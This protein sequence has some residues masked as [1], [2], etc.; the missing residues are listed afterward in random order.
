MCLY[1]DDR[2]QYATI[3]SILYGPYLLAGHST[4]DWDVKTGSAQSLS[5]WITPVPT[6]YNQF[7]VTF[8]QKSGHSTFV[9]ANSNHTLTMEKYPAVGTDAALRATFRLILSDKPSSRS[10]SFK[11][12]IGKSVMLEPIN[13]PGMLVSRDER[14]NKLV[15]TSSSSNT[16]SSIFKLVAGVDGNTETVSLESIGQKGCFIS[17]GTKHSSGMKLSCGEELSQAGYN[18]AASFV[19]GEGVS[20]YH[21]ISFIA[22]GAKQDFLLQP[23]LSFMDEFYT[24]HFNIQV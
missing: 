20:K 17:G 6:S 4:G 15:V 10:S 12:Y 24:V 1:S 16:G 19:I 11:D 21:P 14:N 23:L 13:F 9:L 18:N 5:D 2:S 3:Q 8:T 7:L 22:K